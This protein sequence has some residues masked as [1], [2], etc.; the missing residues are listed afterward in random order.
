MGGVSV[1][2]IPLGGRL[3]LVKSC[4]YTILER[5]GHLRL[6]LHNLKYYR[7]HQ[8]FTKSCETRWLSAGLI[9]VVSKG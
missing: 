6:R 1:I 8:M 9:T 5:V 3:Y 7:Q 2:F 4:T